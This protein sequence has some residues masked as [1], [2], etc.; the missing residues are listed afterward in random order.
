MSPP[1][2]TLDSD[3]R[4]SAR[5]RDAFL[6]SLAVIV[7]EISYTRVFSFKLLY[8]FTYV[9]IGLCLL[10]LGTGG[11]AVTLVRSLRD[12]A[13]GRVI[14][15]AT[16]VAAAAIL[17]GYFVVAWTPLNL[18]L[19]ARQASSGAVSAALPE[20]LKFAFVIAVLFVPFLAAGV[21]LAKIFSS[22]PTRFARLYLADLVGAGLG[23]ALV[24]PLMQ[25]ITPPGVV[26]LA[27][28]LIAVVAWD[29]ASARNA[30]LV[31]GRRGLALV[32]LLGAL[33]PSR[34]PDPVPDEAKPALHGT[35]A[36]FSQW[37]PVFRVD[38]LPPSFSKPV[39]RF[40]VH[41]GQLGSALYAYDGDP[42]SLGRY[43]ASDRSYPFRVVGD[44]PRVAIIGSAGGNEILASLRFGSPS[45]TGIELNP[46]T[47][48]LLRDHFADFTGH[49]ADDPR[50]NLINADGRSYL[51]AT[52]EEFDLVWLVAP[53]S[54][55]AMNA[56]TS[57]AFVLSESYLYTEEMILDA[58]ARLSDGGVLT[59]QFGELDFEN[60][61]NRTLRFLST[62][63]NAL[64][65]R[66]VDDFAS[67]VLVAR[68]GKRMMGSST[69]LLS[70]KAFAESD[71]A[72]LEEAAES[73]DG[74]A[75]EY[76]KLRPGDSSVRPVIELDRDE[77]DRWYADHAFDVKGIDDDRPFFWNFVRF[78]DLWTGEGGANVVTVEEGIGERLL[79]AFLFLAILFAAMVLAAPVLLLRAT[80]SEIPGKARAA[81][82]F[83]ALGI[84]FMLIELSLIQKLSL[85]LGYP[86]YSLTVT[87]FALLMS[88]GV[89]S[90]LS[91]RFSADGPR[92]FRF[93]VAGVALT[94]LVLQLSISQLV[95][96]GI[97]W[98]F[99]V[100]VLLTISL[101]A[102]LGLCMGGFMPLGMRALA[103]PGAHQSELVAWCWAINGF[104]SVVG[105]CL[106]TI[107]SMSLGFKVVLALGVAVYVL[108]VTAVPTRRAAP[109]S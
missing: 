87:L 84:G 104:F 108:G 51:K 22:Q 26:F 105:S 83:G 40:L 109:A 25:W 75:L 79:F 65:R 53:D 89:G 33:L 21:A 101:I 42:A 8:Y 95:A 11:V 55:A 56:A 67:H 97:G 103:R 58:M 39:V 45:I 41:D 4:S 5:Y 2:P 57:G 73:V 20:V 29:G 70:E 68:S 50:V 91:D 74:G 37:S 14:A 93:L 63:R 92:V 17:L 61:P 43:D 77:L 62:A 38:V 47:V 18:L 54:Y 36:G 24:V 3:D 19:M 86:T 1:D 96:H 80:W 66:G 49:V 88:T 27:G 16:T 35:A 90:L 32:L 7:L 64:E 76:A 106:T 34:L 28:F 48:S 44:E 9:L 85:F 98:P 100:R 6:I 59:A 52:D 72:A 12:G 13:P 81:L 102:P 23:C 94:T 30:S 107:L 15:S 99:P 60:K 71:V 82:Y 78:A 31:W 10:G 69:I 46:V